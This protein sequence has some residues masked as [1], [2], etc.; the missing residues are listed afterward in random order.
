MRREWPWLAAG[1]AM[2][3][4]GLAGLVA[5]SHLTHPA[6]SLTYVVGAAAAHDLVAAPLAFA[7]GRGLRRVVPK[8]V[9]PAVSSASWISA[10]VLLVAWPA[11][12]GFGRLRT[13]ATVLPRDYEEGLW[14]TLASVWAATF[15]AT[16]VV[17]VAR[18]RPPTTLISPRRRHRPF[19]D[20]VAAVDREG[21]AGDE[22]GRG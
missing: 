22:V 4:A 9:R 8:A 13:N 11:V 14:L 16:T 21:D 1:G 2:V 10:V 19:A 15:L 20:G 5:D 12:R 17:A 3:A 7:A 6:A 18:R